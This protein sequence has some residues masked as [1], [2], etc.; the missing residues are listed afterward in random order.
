MT[1]IILADNYPL[2]AEGIKCLAKAHGMQLVDVVSSI[3]ELLGKLEQNR[4]DIILLEIA[5]QEE[6]GMESLKQLKKIYPDIPVLILSKYPEE[7]YA[8]RTF[9]IGA[10]GYLN[11]S[12]GPQE[13]IR[14]IKTIVNERRRYITQKVADVL[15]EELNFEQD[16]VNPLHQILS[17]REEQ[18]LLLIARGFKVS[19]IAEKLHLSSH[20]IHTYRSR[21]LKKLNIKSNSDIT[22]YALTH[23]LIN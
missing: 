14:A 19:E 12:V 4:P 8:I 21:I 1:N 11:K 22:H 5:M 6:N 15:V 3:E 13:F 10:H 7:R 2:V 20:T 18:I 9:K 16:K 23:D 17:N